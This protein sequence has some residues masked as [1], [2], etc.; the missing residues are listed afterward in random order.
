MPDL[1]GVEHALVQTVAT[2]LFGGMGYSEGSYVS[3]APSGSQV[4]VYRGWPTATVLDRDIAAG[5]SHVT[6][7]I[8]S[9][10]TQLISRY[11]PSWVQGAYVEPTLTATVAGQTVTLGGTASAGQVVG[12]QFG[13]GPHKSGFA[14]RLTGTDTTATAAAALAAKVSGATVAGSVITLPTTAANPSAAVVS[15][16]LASIELRR[17][18]QGFRI[19]CF[20]PSPLV[21]DAVAGAVDGAFALLLDASGN[22]SQFVT[23][24]TGEAIRV[25]YR[26]TYV[27]DATGKDAVWRRDL[28]FTAEYGTTLAQSQPS[29]LFAA[30]N[31]AANGGAATI[32]GTSDA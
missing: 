23:T 3:F 15:D 11:S 4:A 10:M 2:A 6:V 18:T 9:G 5:K 29:I 1:A 16:Q 7:F 13:N 20:C 17:Q 24:A 14:Y 32:V 27:I 8:E 21:R 22:P 30:A 12:V 31:I 25:R 19:S 28:C 26:S